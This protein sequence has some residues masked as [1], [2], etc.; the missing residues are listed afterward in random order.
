[1]VRQAPIRKCRQINGKCRVKIRIRKGW[2]EGKRINLNF[3]AQIDSLTG[4]NKVIVG[5]S[6]GVDSSVAAYLLKQQG[7]QVSGVTMALWDGQ[8]QSTGKHACYGS[9]EEEEIR[10][11]SELARKLGIS[12]HVYD[13][14][15][16]YRESVLQY[17]KSEYIAGRTPNPCVKCNQLI[18]FGLLPE[19]AEKEGL[20][21]DFF[22]TGHYAKTGWSEEKQ[23]FLLKKGVDIHKD[24]TYFIYR[25][26]QE[27]LSRIIFPLGGY[28]KTEIKALAREVGITM[29]D[30][31]ESQDFYGG[32]YKELLDAPETPG[33]IV[34]SKGKVLGSHKGIW[35]YTIGQRKGMGIA[36]TEPLYVI[37]FDK[38]KNTV[39]VGNREETFSTSFFV[40]DLN[41]I[42]IEQLLRPMEVQCKIRSAQKE[43]DALIE[44]LENGEIKVTF[45]HPSDS[46]TPGQSAVF[47]EGDEVVGGGIIKSIRN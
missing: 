5:L 23:R 11:A 12:H 27:Q 20:Q 8:Y 17:F 14:S 15:S 2:N 18:K 3:A 46:I 35:N 33:D 41:W 21:F 43:K 1:M 16:A 29:V 7:Y 6:G 26:S 40:N 28:T 47:Y 4:K 10:E 22:A 9:D 25:L 30:M 42:S 32:D 39:I 44:P 13:C 34:D 19:M 36:H 31:E 45:F 38:E 24:Q 37:A